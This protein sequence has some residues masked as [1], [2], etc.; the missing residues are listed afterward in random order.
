MAINQSVKIMIQF[1]NKQLTIPINP[2]EITISRTAEN[3]DIK[4]VGLG[5]VTRKGDVGLISI[6][7]E[8][9]FPSSSSYF[10]TGV[11]PKTCIDF[12]NTIW[13]TDN[14]NNNVAKILTSGLPVNVSM[15][16]VINNFNYTYKAGE[17]NDI[18]YT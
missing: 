14:K 5:N 3:E 7:I 11:K 12:L 1:N 2:E 8:S 10:Y 16:F 13:K 17:E 6:T 18:Y 4:V 15:Y 9:F